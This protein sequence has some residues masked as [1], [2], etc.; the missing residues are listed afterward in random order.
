MQYNFMKNTI[1]TLV[2]SSLIF[3]GGESISKPQRPEIGPEAQKPE[4]QK[5]RFPKHWGHPPKI[6]VRDRVKLP[7]KFGFG[8]STL[9]KWISDNLKRDSRQEKPEV[10]KKPPQQEKPKPPAKPLP[11]IV[12]LPPAEVK[13]K[14]EQY[15]RGQ[16]LIQEKL[17]EKIN[18]LGEKPSR[19]SV[20]KTIEKYKKDNKQLI[21]SQKKLGEA[22][23]EW[24]K[25][26]KPSRPKRPAP[27]EEIREKIEKVK[28][29]EK[30]LEGVRKAFQEA[31]KRSKDLSKEDR[32]KLI[33]EFKETNAEKHKAIKDAQKELQKKI[34]ETKQDG[35]RRK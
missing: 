16:K 3:V 20:R 8:S 24:Q 9:S 30:A 25:D 15:K 17:K 4:I 32:A 34:R 29:S 10:E 14:I 35:D 12:P 19:E 13:D 31:L 5:P 1:K 21:E 26:N 18:D 2:V 28:E 7:G 6:Q 27:T 11:P 23:N 33:K 22:I